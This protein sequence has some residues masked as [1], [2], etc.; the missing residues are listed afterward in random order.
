[1]TAWTT[2]RDGAGIWTETGRDHD[3]PRS[4]ATAFLACLAGLVL[5]VGLVAAGRALMCATHK[6]PDGQPTISYCDGYAR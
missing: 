5:M 1:M 2:P 3:T 6:G 4:I